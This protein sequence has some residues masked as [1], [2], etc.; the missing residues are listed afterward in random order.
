MSRLLKWLID[1]VHAIRH[2][3]HIHYNPQSFPLWFTLASISWRRNSSLGKEYY[4]DFN[5]LKR[6]LQGRREDAASF[7]HL[8]TIAQKLTDSSS[9]DQRTERMLPTT[10]TILER[11][12]I[13]KKKTAVCLEWRT[14]ARRGGR[15][16]ANPRSKR[17][18]SF[19]RETKS[20][21]RLRIR[22][23]N[24]KIYYVNAFLYRKKD[25]GSSNIPQSLAEELPTDDI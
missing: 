11:Q 20:T 22:Q 7:R 16:F 17:P 13:K 4:L 6:L 8:Y 23:A 1:S 19:E 3:C 2:F 10:S 14:F 21:L 15:M 25:G 12:S 5:K 24:Q 9:V 18:N